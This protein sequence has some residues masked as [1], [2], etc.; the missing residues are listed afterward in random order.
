M[1]ISIDF[2]GTMWSHMQFFRDF[3]RAM[4][5]A[6]HEVGCLTGHNDDIEGRHQ[7][8][9]LRLMDSRGFPEPDFWFG[10]TPEFVPLNGAV[11]K[12]MVILREGIDIHFDDCDFGNPETL[13]LFKKHLGE[14][15][16]RLMIVKER[17]PTTT[18]FE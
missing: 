11:Y 3:M 15:F 18:H 10:R 1:K 8:N 2:D 13:E 4:Q 12:S 16:H 7:M 14:Q 17:Q 6:G 9:D 5:S